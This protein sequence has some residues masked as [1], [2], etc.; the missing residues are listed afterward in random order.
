MPRA[1][2]QMPPLSDLHCK[3][4]AL[5]R[6]FQ[7]WNRVFELSECLAQVLVLWLMSAA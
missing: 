5:G 2:V 4:R 3:R 7:W 1:I 6:S